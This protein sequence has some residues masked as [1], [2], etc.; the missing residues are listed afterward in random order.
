MNKI[1]LMLL[2]A[3]LATACSST[4]NTLVSETSSNNESVSENVEIP[5]E[6]P[7]NWHHLTSDAD[8]IG[9]GTEKLYSEILL[10][11]TPSKKVI[12]AI[13]DSGT[14]IEH[15]DL[16]EN[17]WINEDEIPGNGIDDDKNGYIDDVHGW[18]FIGGKD[19]NN[20]DKDTYE[21]TR[22]YIKLRDQFKDS[23]ESSL[24]DQQ[25]E[26]FEYYKKIKTEFE[27]KR[28]EA[29][30]NFENLQ[31]IKNAIQGAKSIFNVSS[32]DSVSNKELEPN[33]NDGPYQK[34]AKQVIKYFRDLGVTEDDI[35][36]AYKQF[37]K[38]YNYAYN[39]DFDPRYIVGDDYEDLSNRFYGNNDVEG[40]RS[41]HGSHV[42]GIVG[43]IRDNELGMNGIS[44]NVSLMIVRTVP[45][46][47]ER[48]KDVANAI[49][50][51]VENGADI[52]NMSF[53]KAY[54]PQKFYVDEAMKFAD[55]NNVLLISG[56]GNSAENIDST[57]SYPNKFYDDGGVMKNYLAVGASSWLS[58]SLL[59]AEF[60][61]YGTRVDLFAPG[62]DIYSTTPDNTYEAFSGTSMASPAVAGAAALL[63][64][65]YPELTAYEI[66]M[67]L[68]ESVTKPS[69]VVYK[70]GSD[71]AVPFSELSATGGIL[72]IYE[73][74]RL[75]EIKTS[76]SN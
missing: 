30:T 59:A 69:N 35:N 75:A 12:V 2:A 61:N 53:G 22:V 16:A 38:M 19:G 37:D 70:P 71:I 58:D 49:R 45:D 29:K 5:E 67:I 31:N 39:P 72:N 65:Y 43:A 14:D 27:E 74:F 57:I 6:A 47:D 10:T 60:S 21:L 24:D 51:A 23:D 11:R 33:Y 73:A 41:D 9:I 25:K 64:S 50:Y 66:K 40:P 18:N 52:I 7:D 36:D 76:G 26:E 56:S 55:E 1:I 68:L 8:H 15:E 17:I 32:I 28:A 42:A 46:G 48:D 54:S 34:Q 13:I 20:V 62:V 3:F 4:N 44:G 63:M